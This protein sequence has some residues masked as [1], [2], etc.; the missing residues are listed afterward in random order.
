VN[1]K[2]GKM[3]AYPSNNSRSILIPLTDVRPT[4]KSRIR[5]CNADVAEQG[6]VARHIQIWPREFNVDLNTDLYSPTTELVI[7]ALAECVY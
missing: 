1:L 2:T 4:A 7:I 3:S 6:V 5:S